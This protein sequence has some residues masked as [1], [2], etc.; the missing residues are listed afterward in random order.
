MKLLES[1]PLPWR[2]EYDSNVDPEKFCGCFTIYSSNGKEV[3]EAAS[4]SGDGDTICLT[5]SEAIE[6]VA[7]IN[8]TGMGPFLGD[9]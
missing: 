8:S 7:I 1:F 2:I 5:W 3:M 4:Y 9:E 6:L